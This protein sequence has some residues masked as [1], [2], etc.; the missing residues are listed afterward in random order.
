MSYSPPTGKEKKVLASVS[1][2]AI[3]LHD[4]LESIHLDFGS[5][6][7]EISHAREGVRTNGTEKTTTVLDVV[8]KADEIFHRYQRQLRNMQKVEDKIITV[9]DRIRLKMEELPLCPHCKGLKGYGRD[10]IPKK[11]EAGSGVGMAIK[12]WEDCEVCDGRGVIV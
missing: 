9:I 2:G 3:D 10:G 12:Q 11:W 4:L 8:D 5:A 1:N 7:I 6:Y